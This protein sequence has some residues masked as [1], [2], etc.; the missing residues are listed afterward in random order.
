MT[1]ENL[2]A[3][4]SKLEDKTF[5]PDKIADDPEF[6]RE[7][8]RQTN[9][10]RLASGQFVK[11]LEERGEEQK[12]Q[13]IKNITLLYPLS[14]SIVFT[15]LEKFSSSQ[16][17]IVKTFDLHQQLADQMRKFLEEVVKKVGATQETL[18]NK[19]RYE[20]FIK[21]LE[22]NKRN[23]QEVNALAIEVEKLEEEVE[24]L[25]KERDA[26]HIAEKL[27]NLNDEKVKLEE[28][29]SQNKKICESREKE[30]KDLREEN[31]KLAKEL[32][33]L[34]KQGYIQEPELMRKLFKSFPVDAEEKG[35]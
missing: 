13:I 14:R 17:Y 23:V 30:V 27:K 9:S 2:A 5:E 34:E 1:D 28:S 24:K 22:E 8:F 11:A 3:L 25:R 7:F 15:L 12:T 26:G 16:R 20:T 19:R 32:S 10:Q 29:I 33:N 21:E 35:R 31:K 6:L 4:L 18:D